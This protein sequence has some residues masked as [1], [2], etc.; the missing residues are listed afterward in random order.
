MNGS[1]AKAFSSEVDTGSRQE[2][3]QNKETEPRFDSIETEKALVLKEGLFRPQPADAPGRQNQDGKHEQD[4]DR[5]R[6]LGHSFNQPWH[7][8]EFLDSP[9][10][11]SN[12]I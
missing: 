10:S 2:T 7:F 6:S 11:I 5:K 3:R 12:I 1:A 8:D 9:S 4:D